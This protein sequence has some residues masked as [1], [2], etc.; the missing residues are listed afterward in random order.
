MNQIYSKQSF[1]VYRADG[2][3]VVHNTEK[4]FEEGHTHLSSFKSA[5]YLVD[6]ALHKSLPY[7]LDTYRLVS[8]ARISIDEEYKS[9]VMELVSNK[10]QKDKYVNS[11][12]KC[13]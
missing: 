5:K 6:L 7:H 9:K 4:R 11:R 10:R 3:F 1:K 13:G 8:L 2:G 12:R